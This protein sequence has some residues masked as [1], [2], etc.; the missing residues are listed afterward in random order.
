[1]LRPMSRLRL[2]LSRG[3][4]A[5]ERLCIQISP[6]MLTFAP[7]PSASGSGWDRMFNCRSTSKKELSVLS[8]ARLES[9][10]RREEKVSMLVSVEAPP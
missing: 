8:R 9:R 3:A 2:A 7:Y 10:A 6:S 5:P 4:Q 1:M